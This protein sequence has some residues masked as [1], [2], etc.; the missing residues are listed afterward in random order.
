[1]WQIQNILL[2]DSIFWTAYYQVWYLH[3]FSERKITGYTIA[4]WSKSWSQIMTWKS[5]LRFQVTRYMQLVDLWG[6]WRAGKFFWFYYSLV[7]YE[8]KVATGHAHIIIAG[9]NSWPVAL[10]DSPAIQKMFN[11]ILQENSKI[12]CWQMNN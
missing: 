7:S 11:G 9:E 4:H 2:S 12:S 6:N 3:I 5:G 8:I 1:M 10:G